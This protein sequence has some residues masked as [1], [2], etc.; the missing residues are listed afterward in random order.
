MRLLPILSLFSTLLALSSAAVPDFTNTLQEP[1][2]RIPSVYALHFPIGADAER[3]VR[4]S[5][6]AKGLKVVVRV[7]QSGRIANM[8]SFEVVGGHESTDIL[9]IPQATQAHF[10]NRIAKPQLA[11]PVLKPDQ[12][13]PE[14]IHTLTGVNTA[15]ENLGL[16]GKGI[17]VGV[18]DTGVYYKHRALGGCFGPGCRVES[19]YDFVG[20]DFTG[21]PKIDPVPDED[22]ID[23][24]ADSAHGSHV[25]GIVGANALEF[26]D[27]PEDE[28]PAYPFTGV[29]PDVRIGAYRAAAIYRAA[30]EG[31]HVINLS[32]GGGPNY[33]EEVSAI[34]AD[35]VGKLGHFVVGSNGNDGTGGAFTQGGVGISDGAIA[36]G[37]FDNLEQPETVL[38][39]DG[40]IFGLT[41]SSNNGTFPKGD[42]DWDWVLTDPEN[43]TPQDGCADEFAVSP[44]GKV[45][46]I[47]FGLNTEEGYC[48]SVARCNAAAA[49]GA[50]ACIT[51]A[52]T[53]VPLNIAGSALIPSAAIPRA[54]GLAFLAAYK[55]NRTIKVTFNPDVKELLPIA[56]AG[57]PSDFSSWG[58][59]PELYI[60]PDVSGIG[61][62][63]YSSISPAAANG[64]ALYGLLSGTSMSSPYVAGTIALLVEAQPNITF[65][66]VKSRLLT[67]ATPSKIYGSTLT[68]ATTYDSVAKQGAGLVEITNAILSKTVIS[69][70]SISLNDT[71]RIKQH[72]RVDFKN[73]RDV[74]VTYFLSHEPAA[75][76]YPFNANDDIM[77]QT[78]LSLYSTES[79]NV[80][81]KQSVKVGPNSTGSLRIQF[82]PPVGVDASRYP[83][84]SGYIAIRN[85][86][87][88]IVQRVAYAGL[89]GD[90]AQAPSFSTNSPSLNAALASQPLFQSLG[91]TEN[92]TAAVGAY[93]PTASGGFEPFVPQPAGT[94]LPA[95]SVR[96]TM[97]LL[98]PFSTTTRGFRVEVEY[99]GSNRTIK[100][101]IRDVTGGSN[102][103]KKAT[104]IVDVQSVSVPEGATEPVY[105]EVG[106]LVGS[107][108]QRSSA[109]GGQ[110]LALPSLFMWTGKIWLKED[111]KA[112]VDLP[113]GE[114]RIKF[115]A[116]RH[117]RRV[118]GGA[119]DYEV[120]RSGTF[121][122]T[123]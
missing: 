7:K 61:G 57:T 83:I 105:A 42:N 68:P 17:K 24:C 84:Y 71:K 119:V 69:P 49:A 90:W 62:F 20:D 28:K 116:M 123:L 95:L 80:V 100:S 94:S 15:R 112:P 8:I 27:W 77:P 91:Y 120:V 12:A 81:F 70:P 63:V 93:I 35:T 117:F 29:A 78:D 30:E 33:A 115:E 40:Q 52:P 50:I 113:E 16:T 37:S 89:V 102:V 98:T 60:K 1:V 72:Y 86:Q 47:R 13:K 25:A 45:A 19:G 48:G 6:E 43:K 97:L 4:D 121:R 21:D 104:M 79:A 106:P 59:S 46:I 118:E 66:E 64:G 31:C 9:D 11:T 101:W 58:L 111:S 74:E 75:L 110:S 34:A 87:D 109:T 76:F 55:E 36:I 41:P 53:E 92:S 32:I 82:Q 73:Q 107:T 114:W 54:A 22:P 39:I 44:K 108:A 103:G 5:L 67:T 38:K 99:M 122:W 56:T 51:Y 85:D 18:I 10:V 96:E 23:D 26:G 88:D 3:I 14:Q 2:N 65:P